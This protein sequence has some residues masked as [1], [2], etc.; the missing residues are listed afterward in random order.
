MCGVGYQSKR[1]LDDI[2]RQIEKHLTPFFR[3]RK[4]TSITTTAANGDG[5][6]DFEFRTLMIPAGTTNDV[7]HRL[8]DNDAAN[9]D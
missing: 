6:L 4:V 8:V 2:E 5:A 3:N 1:S 9:D 7:M